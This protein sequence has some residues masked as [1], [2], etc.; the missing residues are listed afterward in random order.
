MFVRALRAIRR[1]ATY[2]NV[3][4]T[5]ALAC[6]VVG[7]AHAAGIGSG[8]ILDNSVLSRDIRNGTIASTDIATGG[9]GLPDLSAQARRAL[10]GARGPAGEDGADGTKGATG[11][12]G[13]TGPVGPRGP[14]GQAG[15]DGTTVDSISDLA[16]LGC[17]AG[18]RE[19]EVVVDIGE[20]T[21]N[22]APV[23]ISCV[24]PDFT[25][26]T[27]NDPP[28]GMHVTFEC[29][30]QT[31]SWV[32]G[33][34]EYG[35]LDIDGNLSNGCEYDA[36]GDA[37]ADE[38]CNG[39]DD[40]WDGAADEGLVFPSY[41]NASTRCDGADGWNISCNAGFANSDGVLANGC[42]DFLND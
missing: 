22:T 42:E 4:A 23:S 30:L 26:C 29:N 2:A 28:T 6:V 15:T 21:S 10:R 20:V 36:P 40:D 11:A 35:W 34:C 5:I 27:P 25:S 24:V 7:T 12:R 41:P 18:S 9:V 38:T 8:G 39:I 3:V 19:G 33:D 32:M 1:H 17:T 31:G 14:I 13:A 37:P 16:G